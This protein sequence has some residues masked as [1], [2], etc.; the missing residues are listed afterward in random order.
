MEQALM[1][2][3]PEGAYR[4]SSTAGP[5]VRSAMTM[6]G[7]PDQP[8][9]GF[10]GRVLERFDGQPPRGLSHRRPGLR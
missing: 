4:A 1:L 7:A 9:A 6:H 10:A 2:A 3:E 8:S 5:P